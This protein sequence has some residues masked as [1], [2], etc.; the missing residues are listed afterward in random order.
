MYFDD[1][2][3]LLHYLYFVLQIIHG[4]HGRDPRSVTLIQSSKDL[5]IELVGLTRTG[6]FIN[7][8][9]SDSVAAMCGLL[10]VGDQI[11]EVDGN[12]SGK[13]LCQCV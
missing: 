3:P 13:S 9:S 6:I 7:S 11:L 1:F 12:N 8:L 2:F 4:K 5:G 10:Q